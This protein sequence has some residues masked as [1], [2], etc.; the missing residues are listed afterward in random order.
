MAPLS[1]IIQKTFVDIK[2]FFDELKGICDLTKVKFVVNLT[3][4]LEISFFVI[5]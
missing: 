1:A 4:G 5:S 2:S 3:K